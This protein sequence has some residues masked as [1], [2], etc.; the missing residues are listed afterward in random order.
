MK[1]TQFNTSPTIK[2]LGGGRKVGCGSCNKGGYQQSYA[3]PQVQGNGYSN[4]VYPQQTAYMPQQTSAV[5]VNPQMQTQYAAPSAQNSYNPYSVYAPPV[6]NYNYGGKCQCC[7]NWYNP[8]NTPAYGTQRIDNYRGY[9]Q[10][11]GEY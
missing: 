7:G 1:R 3:A 9:L 5:G 8:Y 10:G 6:N 2:N 4:Q 11:N